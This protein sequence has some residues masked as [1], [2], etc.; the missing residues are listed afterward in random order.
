[1][2]YSDCKGQ[3]FILRLFSMLRILAYFGQPCIFPEWKGPESVWG[4]SVQKMFIDLTLIRWLQV[5]INL[6]VQISCISTQDIKLSCIHCKLFKCRKP[7]VVDLYS[8]ITNI[9]YIRK[10]D[11]CALPEYRLALMQE[12]KSSAKLNILSCKP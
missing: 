1:M 7:S 12:E 8:Y 10:W 2:R 3:V 4:Y 5:F 9:C 6:L 11:S